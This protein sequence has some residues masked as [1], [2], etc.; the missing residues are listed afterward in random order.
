MVASC[1]TAREE[2]YLA[3]AASAGAAAV[4]AVVAVVEAVDSVEAAGAAAGAAA[5]WLKATLEPRVRSAAI[6][7]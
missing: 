5:S 7:R 6:E 1:E 3:G 2:T 4:A